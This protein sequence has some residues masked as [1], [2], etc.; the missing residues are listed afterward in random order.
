MVFSPEMEM[1]E[2]PVSYNRDDST[3][4]IVLRKLF[5]HR[6]VEV[7]TGV[8]EPSLHLVAKDHV[9]AFLAVTEGMETVGKF[10][11]PGSGVLADGGSSTRRRPRARRCPGE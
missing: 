7:R 9:V 10:A 2:C 8:V 5:A 1:H 11:H 4:E 3:H 6:F